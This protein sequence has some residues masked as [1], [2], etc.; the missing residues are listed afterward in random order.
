MMQFYNSN[1]ESGINSIKS[2][3]AKIELLLIEYTQNEINKAIIS[4]HILDITTFKNGIIT[5]DMVKVPEKLVVKFNEQLHKNEHNLDKTM[6]VHGQEK[7][8]ILKTNHTYDTTFMRE[9]S[10]L[11]DRTITLYYDKYVRCCARL[12]R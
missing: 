10:N 6:K 2:Q 5:K 11:I 8:F 12:I 4:H 3:S 7:K 9:L 1:I